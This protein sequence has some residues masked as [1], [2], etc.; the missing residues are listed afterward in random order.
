MVESSTQDSWV[1]VVEEETKGLFVLKDLEMLGCDK[2]TGCSDAVVVDGFKML[3]KNVG[4]HEPAWLNRYSTV[5]NAGSL[6]WV[7]GI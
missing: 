2:Y 4:Q 1:V 5:H 7:F 3:G 6:D